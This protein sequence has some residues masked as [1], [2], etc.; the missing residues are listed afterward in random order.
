MLLLLMMMML[1]SV[2]ENRRA[3]IDHEEGMP[4]PTLDD[5][6]NLPE[7]DYQLSIN[8]TLNSEVEDELEYL[9]R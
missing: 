6:W 4:W 5:E 2:I 7:Q 9:I 3:H 8:S 1:C